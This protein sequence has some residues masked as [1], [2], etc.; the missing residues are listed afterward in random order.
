MA[1]EQGN[2]YGLYRPQIYLFGCALKPE[3]KEYKFDVVDEEAEHQLCLKSICLGAEAADEFHTVEIEGLNYEGTM[4]KVQ[5]AVLKPSVI[6][7][8]SLGGFE[9]TPPVTFRLKS[10]SGPVFISGQHFISAKE[11]EDDEEEEEENNT[12]PVK[13][14]SN[15]PSNSLPV[16]K[17]LK[18]DKEVD[19]EDDDEDEDEEYDDDEEEEEKEEKEKGS[20]PKTPQK[21]ETPGKK[22]SEP[23]SVSKQ[24][25][26]PGKTGSPAVKPQPKIPCEKKEKSGATTSLSVNEVKDRLKTMVTKGHALPKSQMKFANFAKYTYKIVDQKVAE[27]LWNHLQKLKAEKK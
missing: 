9:I 20:P 10:G 16:S 19:E 2:A 23:K 3:K 6:P 13:R 27:E 26:A 21:N 4:I 14:L 18:F 24:N 22:K 5:L 12:S 25:C 15:S 8:I 17:K 1:E 11:E 7:T